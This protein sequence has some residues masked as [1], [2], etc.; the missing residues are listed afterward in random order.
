MKKPLE[1]TILFLFIALSVVTVAGG[2]DTSPLEKKAEVIL[3]VKRLSF[4]GADKY[5][6]YK[7]QILEIIKNTSNE[8]FGPILKIAA[9]SWVPGVSEGEST[10]YLE[11]YN[12]DG[13]RLWMLLGGGTTTVDQTTKDSF[14]WDNKRPIDLLKILEAYKG[15]YT[16]AD[17]HKDWVRRSDLPELIKLLDSEKACAPV[18]M[19]I[20]SHDLEVGARSFIGLE[21]L[22]MIDAYQAGQYPAGLFSMHN[23]GSKAA[24]WPYFMK[25]KAEVLEWYKSNF[26]E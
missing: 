17:L 26:P 23:Y 15:V 16:V 6:W 18:R 1:T 5:A 19:S 22:F 24:I 9:Y 10:V 14:D 12:K 20:S 4:D 2:Q 8:T 21:A 3:R 7:V 11:H 25:R 13:K